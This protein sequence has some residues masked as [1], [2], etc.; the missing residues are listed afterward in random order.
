MG[1]SSFGRFRV[2]ANAGME[3]E[4]DEFE[5]RLCI[6]LLYFVLVSPPCEKLQ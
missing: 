5:S 1:S 6:G 3:A 2:L 4:V